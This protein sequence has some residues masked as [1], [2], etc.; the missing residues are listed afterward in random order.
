MKINSVNISYHFSK[1]CRKR[2]VNIFSSHY[3]YKY[4]LRFLNLKK[5]NQFDLVEVYISSCKDFYNKAWRNGETFFHPIEIESSY[6]DSVVIKFFIRR[7]IYFFL[8]PWSVAPFKS[9]IPPRFIPYTSV[10]V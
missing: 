7:Y 1:Y 2:C 6:E 3:I 9:N 5:E 4:S 10:A 8:T